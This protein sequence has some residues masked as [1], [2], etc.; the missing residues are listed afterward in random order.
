MWSGAEQE[1]WSSFFKHWLEMLK[2][3]ASEKQRSIIEVAQRLDLHDEA[4]RPAYQA[5]SFSPCREKDSAT[6]SVQRVRRNAY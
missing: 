5:I 6:G 4:I 2:A 1:K 3:E